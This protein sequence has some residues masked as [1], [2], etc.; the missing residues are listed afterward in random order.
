MTSRQ[1]AVSVYQVVILATAFGSAH[2]DDQITI[3]VIRTIWEKRSGSCRLEWCYDF[4]N[5]FRFSRFQSEWVPTNDRELVAREFVE[6]APSAIRFVGA[7]WAVADHGITQLTRSAATVGRRKPRSLDFYSVLGRRF[8]DRGAE[9]QEPFRFERNAE[10]HR[11]RDLWTRGSDDYPRG[12]L[13]RVDKFGMASAPHGG[14]PVIS[15]RIQ[16]LNLFAAILAVNPL[17]PYLQIDLAKCNLD[18][19][20][21]QA[22]GRTCMVLRQSIHDPRGS[23]ERAFWLGDGPNMEVV[24][25]VVESLDRRAQI[26]IDYIDDASINPQP[27]DWIVTLFG[28]PNDPIQDVSRAIVSDVEMKEMLGIDSS[29]SF[30]LGSWVVN[31][32]EGTQYLLREGG[33]RRLILPQELQSNPTYAAL[34]SSETGGILKRSDVHGA[35]QRLGTSSLISGLFGG[36]LLFAAAALWFR[37]KRTNSS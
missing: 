33:E 15:Q 5:V 36:S 12:T 21:V 35:T 31:E 10:G 28:G 17:H 29:K 4:D 30:P 32:E 22:H 9:L 18:G 6:V 19:E 1:L 23:L 14:E 26:D 3:E 27:A 7:R 25:Y 16:D 37:Q 34:S 13:S 20:R 24:R 8:P 11:V 2:S